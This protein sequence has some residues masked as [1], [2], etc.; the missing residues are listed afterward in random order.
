MFKIKDSSETTGK[1]PAELASVD[2]ILNH[3][4]KFMCSFMVDEALR[5]EYRLVLE[6]VLV[7]LIDKAPENALLT[8]KLIHGMGGRFNLIF[9]CLGSSVV[10]D[11]EGP[12]DFGGKIIHEYRDYLSQA[13]ISGTNHVDI[14]LAYGHFWQRSD[15]IKIG[16]A[17]LF[18]CLLYG[19][20]GREEMYKSTSAIID[21]YVGCLQTIAGPCVCFALAGAI[22]NLYQHFHHNRGLVR[23]FIWYLTT[24]LVAVGIGLSSIFVFEN[25]HLFDDI[26]MRIVTNTVLPN[27]LSAYLKLFTFSNIVQIFEISFPLPMLMLSFLVGLAACASFGPEG[28]AIKQGIAALDNLFAK[29]LSLIYTGLPFIATLIIATVCLLDGPLRVLYNICLWL[30]CFFFFVGVLFLFYAVKLQLDG[31]SIKEFLLD[32][33]EILKRDFMIGSNIDA[34]PFNQRMLRR[35]LTNIETSELRNSLLLGSKVNMTGNCLIISFFSMLM[36]YSADI[37]IIPFLVFNIGLIIILLSVGAPNQPGSFLLGMVFI[38]SFLGMSTESY[39]VIIIMEYILGRTYSCLNCLD[40]IILMVV[41]NKK[42]GK[43]LVKA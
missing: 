21:F 34:L 19:L 14:S 15:F 10:L 36:I 18:F 38:V 26:S 4:D 7:K 12:D 29:M 6:E 31:I 23:I 27:S 17:I 20:T 9:E 2:D 35:K 33:G 3:A 25:L 8:V 30:M 13:Y 37:K 43:K 22:I 5:L 32:Y 28:N 42:R 24:S 39:F 1:F 11:C 41:E 16:V 40:D